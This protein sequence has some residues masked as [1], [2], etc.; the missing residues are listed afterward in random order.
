[1]FPRGASLDETRALIAAADLE[2]AIL[3]QIDAPNGVTLSARYGEVPKAFAIVSVFLWGDCDDE[4]EIYAT[5]ALLFDE[6]RKLFLVAPHIDR[7]GR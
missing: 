4:S 1:M 3:E 6:N 5:V 7:P 2:E